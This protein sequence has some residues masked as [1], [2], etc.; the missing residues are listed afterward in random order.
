MNAKVGDLEKGAYSHDTSR[1][2][3]LVCYAAVNHVTDLS[4]NEHDISE[5]STGHVP[6]S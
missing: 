4:E 1:L 5:R 6:G 2:P 3:P